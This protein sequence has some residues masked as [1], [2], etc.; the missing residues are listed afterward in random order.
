MPKQQIQH[1]KLKSKS[2]EINKITKIEKIHNP[3]LR[4]HWQFNLEKLKEKNH[5]AKIQY[6]RLLWHGSGTLPPTVIY[7]D[8]ESGWK[9]TYATPKNLWGPGLYFGEDASYCHK[10]T[11]VTPEGK[12]QVF[13]AEV[14]TG[15][16][17]ISLEDQNIR[18]PAVK[19][20]DGITHYDS[21]CGVRHETSWIWVVYCN[22]RAY[23]T[24]LVEYE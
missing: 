13:L 19:E 2:K 21:V 16:D 14:I 18:E 11:F 3:S 15:D 23:P 9:T 6:T 20:D 24:Y 7:Q 1:G 5:H 17:I 12:R 4:A 22:G 10:Y 8:N